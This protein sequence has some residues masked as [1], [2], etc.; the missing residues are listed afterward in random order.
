M[1]KRTKT[2]LILMIVFAVTTA[3][4]GVWAG[5]ATAKN[6]RYNTELELGYQQT[7][8]ELL[9][10]VNDMEVRVAKL[11]VT[12]SEAA[13]KQL[14][15]EVWKGSEVCLNCLAGLSS[16]DG[17]VGDAVKFLNQ[18]GDYCYYLAV[19]LEQGEALDDE[20]K[21][22]LGKLR[23]MLRSLGVE[24]N[25]VK[26]A[27]AE[28]YL[29]MEDF[30]GEN[31]I[32]SVTLSSLSGD[33]VEYPQLIYDGPFS[34]SRNEKDIKMQLGEVV[35]AEQGEQ[36][37]RELLNA[38]TVSAVAFKGEWAT[39]IP[40]LN[41]E[42]T[43]DEAGVVTVQLTQNGGFP[44]TIAAHRDVGEE[45]LS[46]DECAEIARQYLVKLGINDMQAVWK[47]NSN[48]VVY[49]NLAP[50]VD[51]IVYYPDLIKVKVAADNGQI[52]GL[53][54]NSYIFNHT[55]RS[56]P[57]AALSAAEAK[58]KIDGTLAPEGGR[59]ALIPLDAEEILTYEFTAESGGTYYIYI[60]AVTG[61]E[62][63]ILYVIE[64]DSGELIM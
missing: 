32:L 36:R 33:S 53:E 41:Y 23:E 44:I 60:N 59:L 10:Q 16:R 31:D 18:A 35:T 48:G 46:N 39:D 12:A 30:G 57:K 7:Y 26:E 42:V 49:V 5:L 29:F 45:K 17:S 11:G 21:D 40:S 3:G 56:L 28:G 38:Y 55:E 15:Y 51:D 25:K 13:Q 4:L 54:A 52:L 27:I 47:S 62:E 34:D 61:E 64:S 6:D 50:V 24:L 58:A 37:A 2:F 19:R 1:D 14:L 63:N 8:F 20:A 43:T 9:S 22:S